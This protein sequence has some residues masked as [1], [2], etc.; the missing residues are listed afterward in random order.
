MYKIDTPNGRLP[1]SQLT[2]RNYTT[3]ATAWCKTKHHVINYD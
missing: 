2:L 1:E 3:H